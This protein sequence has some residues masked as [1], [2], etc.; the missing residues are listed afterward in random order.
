MPNKDDDL[1]TAA[2]ILELLAER[3]KRIAALE[4][5]QGKQSSAITIL[6]KGMQLL[7]S[8]RAG[9]TDKAAEA[10]KNAELLVKE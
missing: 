4:Q 2:E 6:G 8:F 7:R 3:D 1:L 10:G 9:W 5:R